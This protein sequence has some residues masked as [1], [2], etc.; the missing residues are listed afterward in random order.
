MELAKHIY[1]YGLYCLT[2]TYINNRVMVKKTFN[3]GKR[4][5]YQ[6][7]QITINPRLESLWMWSAEATV[8]FE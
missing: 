1:K 6:S 2:F 4:F 8:Q 3:S 7:R 5:R